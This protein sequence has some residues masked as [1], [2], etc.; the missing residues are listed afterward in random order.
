[1]LAHLNVAFELGD[2]KAY[3]PPNF[4]MKWIMKTFIKKHVVNSV[5]YPTNMRTAPYFVIGD[6]RDF[7]KEKDKLIA[8]LNNV[9][10]LG[11][12]HFAGKNSHSFGPLTAIEWSNMFYKHLDHHLRQF[13][14]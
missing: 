8:H 2:E 7:Q 13:D 11:A 5:P 3:P 10:N 4:L 1:M 6:E 9:Y 14:V 12:E